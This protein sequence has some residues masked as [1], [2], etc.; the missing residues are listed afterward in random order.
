MKT[1]TKLLQSNL[2]LSFTLDTMPQVSC[3][4]S[5]FVLE[6]KLLQRWMEACTGTNLYY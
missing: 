5:R 1:Y 4:Q 2:T 6:F 3:H